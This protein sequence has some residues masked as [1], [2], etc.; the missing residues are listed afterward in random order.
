MISISFCSL[1]VSNLIMV[2]LKNLISTMILKNLLDI[3]G[4]GYFD[5]GIFTFTCWMVTTVKV[6]HIYV[7]V[8]SS[9]IAILC[10]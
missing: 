8:A 1:Q 9:T 4:L 5:K 7:F 2:L 6:F 3:A 10:P